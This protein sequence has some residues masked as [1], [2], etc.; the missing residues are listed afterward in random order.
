MH[1]HTTKEPNEKHSLMLTAIKPKFAST[2]NWLVPKCTSFELALVLEKYQAGD[3]V[4][5]DQFVVSTPG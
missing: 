2:S 4:S 1:V 5:M 3:F